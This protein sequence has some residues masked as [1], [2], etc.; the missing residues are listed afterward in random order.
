MRGS[1]VVLALA[2]TLIAA[3]VTNAQSTT[4]NSNAD[5]KR[6][7]QR[8]RGSPS[9][10]G[11]ANRTDP[12]QQGNKDCTPLLG[13]ATISGSVYFDVDEDGLRGA[14]EVGLSGWDVTLS[15]SGIQ[16]QTVKSGDDGVFSFGNLSAGTYLLCVTT[17]PMWTQTGPA[18]GDTCPT[19]KGYSVVVQPSATDTTIDKRN[20]GYITTP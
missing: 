2:M 14:D 4:D 10:S 9:D 6:C 1:R 8:D 18:S 5:D 15:G 19:G 16:P 7:L 11:L 20:F 13:R 12:T 17:L 3:R